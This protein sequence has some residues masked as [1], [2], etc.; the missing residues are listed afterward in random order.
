MTN[1]ISVT[2]QASAPAIAEG[3]RVAGAWMLGPYR[4]LQNAAA[5][6]VTLLVGLGGAGLCFAI[7]LR[8]T[9][10]AEAAL[11]YVWIGT[12]LAI[13][14]FIAVQNWPIRRLARHAAASTYCSG[15]QTAEF[16]ET[17]MVIRNAHSHWQ[18]NWAAVDKIGL[19]KT[20]LIIGVAGLVFTIPRAAL[21][22]PQAAEAKLRNWKE[23]A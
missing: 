5:L 12:V 10:T 9:G 8:A 20:G 15:T 19:G 16:D 17:G 11:P 13:V 18:T 23:A 4:I 22:D 2:Y 14:F 1:R 7:A 3:I 6:L 21:D